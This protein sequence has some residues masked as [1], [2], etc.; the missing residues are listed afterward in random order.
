M[1]FEVCE[2]VTTGLTTTLAHDCRRGGIEV[3]NV[4]STL[5]WM[6]LPLTSSKPHRAAAALDAST[7]EQ[8]A[9]LCSEE[10][11]TCQLISRWSWY[12]QAVQSFLALVCSE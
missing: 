11:S 3:E 4:Q 10:I 2:A 7:S 9:Q 1:E 12:L 5:G 8:T 6:D